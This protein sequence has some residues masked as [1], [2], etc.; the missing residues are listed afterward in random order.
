MKTNF[1]EY[2][3]ELLYVDKNKLSDLNIDPEW[4]VPQV[5]SKNLEYDVDNHIFLF[6]TPHNVD[7]LYDFIITTKGE[8]YIGIG[9][10]KLAK[11]EDVIK[12]AGSLKIN[13]EGKINYIDNTSGHYRPTKNKLNE[14]YELFKSMNL[15]SD[16]VEINYKW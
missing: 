3:T 6:K 1:I 10:Y 8:L 4:R 14:V 2:I 15:L 16:D 11:K 13:N 12:A 5:G 9:H 7:E